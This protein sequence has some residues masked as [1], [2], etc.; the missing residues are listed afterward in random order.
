MPAA[1]VVAEQSATF[2]SQAWRRSAPFV[3][4]C[5]KI[6]IH[7]GHNMPGGARQRRSTHFQVQRTYIY[8]TSQVFT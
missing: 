5:V 1:V 3:E 6:K 7:A 4:L 2:I 8:F